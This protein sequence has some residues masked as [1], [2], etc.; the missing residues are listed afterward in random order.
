MSMSMSIPTHPTPLTLGE[1]KPDGGKMLQLYNLL[2]DNQLHY[3]Y[4]QLEK[5]NITISALVKLSRDYDFI[6]VMKKL[7]LGE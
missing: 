6:M 7:Q 3:L 5:K 4:P 2:A 1:S